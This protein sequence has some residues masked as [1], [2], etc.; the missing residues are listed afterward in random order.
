MSAKDF[1][2]DVWRL[3]CLALAALYVARAY[4]DDGWGVAVGIFLLTFGFACAFNALWEGAAHLCRR[5]KSKE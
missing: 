3:T 5:S 1:V 2:Y 4:R